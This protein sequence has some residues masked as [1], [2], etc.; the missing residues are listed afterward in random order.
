MSVVLRI[1]DVNQKLSVSSQ[2]YGFGI[3]DPGTGENLIRSHCKK[4]S[5]LNSLPNMD[6]SDRTWWP[7]VWPPVSGLCLAAAAAVTGKMR[8]AAGCIPRTWC[9]LC[10]YRC[11]CVRLA[12]WPILP[13]ASAYSGRA[14]I[15][16]LTNFYHL[17]VSLLLFRIKIPNDPKKPKKLVF[18][19][20][21]H[22]FVGTVGFSRR[23][24]IFHWWLKK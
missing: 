8:A 24:E 5:V 23:V 11:A 18:C 15:Q 9:A 6:S 16:H 22:L 7:E 10:C 12:S 4:G 2:K 17:F 19:I 21:E 13:Q 1:R 14:T 20:S 3:R